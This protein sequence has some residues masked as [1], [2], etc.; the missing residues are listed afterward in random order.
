M[1]DLERAKG[2]LYSGSYAFV[3]VKQGQVIASGMRDGLDELLETVVQH[4]GAL[5]GASLADKI[6]GKAVAMVAVY[7]G[8]RDIYTPLGS[9]AAQQVLEANDIVF[10]AERLVPLIRNKR[11]DGPCPMERLTLPIDEPVEAVIALREFVAQRP[12]PVPAVS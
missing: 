1:N 5:R 7:A 8:I 11:D 12:Q 10:Q 6:V 4:G 9:Q 2:F 3:I